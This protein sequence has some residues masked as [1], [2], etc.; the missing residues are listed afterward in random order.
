MNDMTLA[1][2]S[3]ERLLLRFG[4]VRTQIYLS[5]SAAR[6]FRR[7]EP[8]DVLV[9]CYGC[10]SHPFD[11]SAALMGE[12]LEAGY[13]LAYPEYLGTWGSG[14]ACTLEN[15][16]DTVGMVQE[17]LHSGEAMEIRHREFLSW[18]VRRIA[19]FGASFGGSVALVAAARFMPDAVVAV[20]PVIDWRLHGSGPE[21]EED[22]SATYEV[23]EQGYANLW[24]IDRQTYDDLR[25]G[26]L[27][28]NPIDHA[29]RLSRIPA[30]FVHADDDTQV[31]NRNTRVLAERMREHGAP[32]R[33]DFPERGGHLILYH[34]GQPDRAAPVLEWLD[35]ALERDGKGSP[36]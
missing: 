8:T 14:G 34:M 25:L 17:G 20:S 30:L 36:P 13:A 27:D 35:Q 4:E 18:R 24:R 23:I 2:F 6:A 5:V 15:A 28:L 31:S 33:F 3:C 1:A 16:V 32:H 26:R 21:R 7:G 9:M 10:P 19:L 22:L 29:E 12:Y 11:H